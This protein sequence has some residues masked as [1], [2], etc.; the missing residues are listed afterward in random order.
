MR[1]R[2]CMAHVHAC[3]DAEC[4]AEPPTNARLASAIKLDG[5]WNSFQ[6][7]NSAPPLSATDSA[8]APSARMALLLQRLGPR[9]WWRPWPTAV[10]RGS[11]GAAAGLSCAPGWL[12]SCPFGHLQNVPT[13]PHCASGG[14]QCPAAPGSQ[15]CARRRARTASLHGW[16][17]LAN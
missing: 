7:A 1:R 14:I 2:P 6:L 15:A 16:W 4:W 9:S 8:I 5:N 17:Q 10:S 11:S 13:L 12:Q 3:R